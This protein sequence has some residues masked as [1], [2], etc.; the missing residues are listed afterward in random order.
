MNAK[1][2]R[3]FMMFGLLGLAPRE[4]YER[5]ALKYIMEIPAEVL[6]SVPK[7]LPEDERHKRYK[8]N[9]SK[10]SKTLK[11]LFGS[12]F[13]NLGK[14]DVTAVLDFLQEIKIR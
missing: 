12:Q 2:I 11:N 13:D 10:I 4:K 3:I 14:E 9:R 5:Y 1:L 6:E 7:T 8:S